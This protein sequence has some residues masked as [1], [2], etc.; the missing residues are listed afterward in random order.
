M[1][2]ILKLVGE[3]FRIQGELYSYETITVGNINSTYKVT[4]T[5][6]DGGLKSFLFQ[7][8][9]T[10]VFKNPVEIMENIDRVTTHIREKY[11]DQTTLH[12]HHTDDGSNYYI[13]GEDAFW[14]VI[15]YIDSVTFSSSDDLGVIESA[16]FAFGQFQTQ[17]SD[18]D[19]PM[20]NTYSI[21]TTVA[22]KIDAIHWY[23]LICP[24]KASISKH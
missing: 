7:R 4:Y 19:A 2:D 3:K 22:E 18:F 14:R 21:E 1:Y 24:F 10:H 12:F 20:V 23:M 9:N 5:Q 16:G 17:L 6:A 13:C 8:V 11:P 15:N